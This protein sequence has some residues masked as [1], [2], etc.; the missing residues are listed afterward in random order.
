MVLTTKKSNIETNISDKKSFKIETNAAAFEILSKNLYQNIPRAIIRELCTNAIDAN[1]QLNQPLNN[2]EVTLPD[3]STNIFSIEDF[4]VGMSYDD[5]MNV[6]TSFFSSTKSNSNEQTGMFG[7]G[8]KTPFAYTTQFTID[9]T[10]AG[11]KC[12]F[13]V[14]KDENGMPCVSLITRIPVDNNLHGTKI[15]FSVK[16]SDVSQFYQEFLFC[17]QSFPD[18]PKIKENESFLNFLGSK[19]GLSKGSELINLIKLNKLYKKDY[20]YCSEFKN[21]SSTSIKPHVYLEMGS[22][23]YNVDFDVNISTSSVN[24]FVM[25]IIKSATKNGILILHANIGD[26]SITPSR[27]ELQYDEKTLDFIR[28]KTFEVFFTTIIRY[29]SFEDYWKFSYS[30]NKKIFEDIV[31]NADNYL[32]CKKYFTQATIDSIKESEDFLEKMDVLIT[33]AANYLPNKCFFELKSSVDYLESPKCGRI[34]ACSIY[35]TTFTTSTEKLLIRKSF[36]SNFFYNAYKYSS[37]NSSDHIYIVSLNDKLSKNSYVSSGYQ[38][39]SAITWRHRSFIKDYCINNNISDANVVSILYVPN[40]DTAVKKIAS[41][42]NIKILSFEEWQN[43]KNYY[44]KP[45]KPKKGIDDIAVDVYFSSNSFRK[46]VFSQKQDKYLAYEITF[47]EAKE[48]AKKHNAKIFLVPKYRGTPAMPTNIAKY[49]ASPS[50]YKDGFDL[51]VNVPNFLQNIASFSDYTPLIEAIENEKCF[52]VMMNYSSIN[53]NVINETDGIDWM[54][55]FGPMIFNH[56]NTMISN[57]DYDSVKDLEIFPSKL[58]DTKIDTL[59]E[60][61]SNNKVTEKNCLAYKI[62]SAQKDQGTLEGI[63][64][65][66]KNVAYTINSVYNL[67]YDFR[68]FLPQNIEDDYND[69]CSR[70]CNLIDVKYAN[71][72]PITHALINKYPMLYFTERLYSNNNNTSNDDRKIVEYI[73]HEDKLI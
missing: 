18:I 2:F 39:S 46:S 5:V 15:S 35:D 60:F 71:D 23:L 54:S 7:L 50:K 22:V 36:I 14:F 38:Q 58:K 3:Y 66:I 62:I 20:F 10:K 19:L 33:D 45:T 4:G 28:R 52:F 24:E 47:R 51:T 53:T 37:Q 30:N 21:P 31:F 68:L 29:K 32:L 69:L 72:G 11:E 12:I 44:A 25:Q 67:F 63:A 9:T 65:S 1:K 73:L 59:L 26:V 49:L 64:N 70:R 27:E 40:D 6:Y 55:T 57:T 34:I 56:I 48:L 16:S 41:I 17:C 8:S 43:V 61:V 42:F 13:N